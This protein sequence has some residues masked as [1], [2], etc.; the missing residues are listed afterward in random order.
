MSIEARHIGNTIVSSPEQ[1]KGS[2]QHES[3]ENYQENYKELFPD[4]NL[5]NT[6][7]SDDILEEINLLK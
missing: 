2:E 5:E 6:G 4:I 3:L 7:I 1:R